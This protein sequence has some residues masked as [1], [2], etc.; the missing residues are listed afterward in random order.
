[1][2]VLVTARFEHQPG[3]RKMRT[4]VK[5]WPDRVWAVEGATAWVCISRSS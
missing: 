3:Y 5:R 2:T 1:M 4:L